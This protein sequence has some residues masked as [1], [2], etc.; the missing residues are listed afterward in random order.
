MYLF[1]LF[2]MAKTQWYIIELNTWFIQLHVITT[3]CSLFEKATCGVFHFPRIP[4]FTYIIREIVV[5]M[6]LNL[7]GRI[8]NILYEFY[9]GTIQ[10]VDKIWSAAKAIFA[11]FWQ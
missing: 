10:A 3:G 6:F 9:W 5:F 11:A 7:D 2:N 1:I 4:Y 8:G